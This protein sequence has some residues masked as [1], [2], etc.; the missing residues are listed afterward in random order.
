MNKIDFEVI[1]SSL[2]AIARE[3]KIAMMR[4]AASPII[5]AGGDASAAIF[6]SKMQLVAQGNDIP[7]MMGSAVISTKASVEYVGVHNLKPGDVIISNDAY[8]GGGNHQPD[9]QF[10]R[11]VFLDGRIIAYTMT[12][13][14]WQ[15]IGGMT[16]NSGSLATWD[17][18]GEGIRIPPIVLFR[19]DKPVQDLLTIITQNTRDAGNRLLDIQAQYAGCYVGERRLLELV[20]KWGADKLAETMQ[21]SLDYSERLMRKQIEAIPDGVYEAEDH[22]EVVTEGYGDG[23]AVPI[24]VKVTVKGDRILVDY[25]GSGPQVRG[26]VNCPLSVTYNSTWYTIKAMTDPSI[27]INQG[28]YRPIEIV[29]PEGSIVNCKFPAS[30]VGGNTAT[31]QRV[32]DMLLVAFSKAAPRRVIAQS[33]ATAGSLWFGGDDPDAARCKMLQRKFVSAGDLNPGGMGARPDKDGINAIRVH[34]GNAGTQSVEYTEYTAPVFIESWNL[35]PDAGGAGTWRGGAPAM[36]VYHVGYE[37]ATCNVGSERGEF[38]PLGL[39]GGL[40]GALYQCVIEH[41]DGTKERVPPKGRPRVVHKGDRVWIHSAGAGGYG[42]PLVREP[43]RVLE[44]V[45]DGYVTVEAARRDYGVVIAP[46]G[47][48]IDE[49]GTIKLRAE[50]MKTKSSKKGAIHA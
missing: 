2:Y 24:K 25:T 39:F 13:G 26:G 46:D 50:R 1:R 36:R 8:L 41:T 21:E 5:H 23:G 14:H 9:V 22:V 48:S 34:V 28:C 44:D 20:A 31:S 18:F 10:T 45:L 11:P 4:T 43:K 37:E 27:P 7:T 3:M 16:P 19:E 12:R 6:D 47:E 42:D 38:P 35:V 30:V 40:E 15:D 49:T 17:I 29:A 33:H 32:I